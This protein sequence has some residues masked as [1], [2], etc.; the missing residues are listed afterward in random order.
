MNFQN[1][2]MGKLDTSL[3]SVYYNFQNQFNQ[4]L[5][6]EISENCKSLLDVG[7]GFNS[8]VQFLKPR[9]KHLV[10]IDLHQSAIEQSQSLGIH[11][12]YMQI[13]VLEI[14]RYFEPRSFDYVIALDLIEHLKKEQGYKLISKLE[15]IAEKKVIIFTPNGFLPQG[16][17]YGNPMQ[18]HLSGWSSSEI[19]ELGYRVYGIE[20]FKPIRGEMAQIK[21]KPTWFWLTLSLITQPF[22]YKI[23]DF[24]FRLFC[25]K[26]IVS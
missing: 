18:K 22:V 16:E 24:A 3:K 14:D 11:D 23:P 15:L 17:E 8:P 26:D 7:C 25:V 1:K 9:P 19:K 13:D 2:M 4:Y 5:R 6:A 10:G 20:G 12:E 21:F